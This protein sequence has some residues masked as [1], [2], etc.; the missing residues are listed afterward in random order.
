MTMIQD[1]LD[2]ASVEQPAIIVPGHRIHVYEDNACWY[3]WLNTEVQDFDGLCLG[4]GS[5]RN[6]AIE[7]AVAALEG[8]IEALQ[9]PAPLPS[10]AM[11][12]PPGGER[13]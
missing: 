3:V 11:P 8:I 7:D 13:R 5:T 9:R 6:D 10:T 2:K 12:E 1:R 4:T